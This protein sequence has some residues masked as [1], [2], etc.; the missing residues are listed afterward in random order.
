[1]TETI[2]RIVLEDSMM[3]SLSISK[4]VPENAKVTC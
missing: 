4:P 2:R 1:M 3:E